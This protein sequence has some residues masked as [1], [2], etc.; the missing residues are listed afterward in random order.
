MY[1]LYIK[2][3]VDTEILIRGGV[4]FRFAIRSLNIKGRQ[5]WQL[6]RRMTNQK[7]TKSTESDVLMNA[8]HS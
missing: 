4:I 5:G 8:V 3:E 7:L 2:G 6:R 1:V